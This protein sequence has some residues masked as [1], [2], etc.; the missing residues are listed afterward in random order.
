NSTLSMQT[1]GAWNIDWKGPSV[2]DVRKAGNNLTDWHVAIDEYH[3]Y[4]EDLDLMQEM[5]MNM[6]RIQISWSRVNPTGNGEFNDK[7]IAFYDRLINAMLKR[8]I[9]SEEHTSELQSRFDLVCRLLL[10]T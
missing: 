6:Y 9:R 1:E 8:E 7:G 4:E 10:E 5:G 3:R 2:Y